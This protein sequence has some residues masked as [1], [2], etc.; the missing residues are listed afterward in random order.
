L[1]AKVAVIDVVPGSA[2]KVARQAASQWGVESFSFDGDMTQWGSV[3]SAVKAI[4]ERFGRID[5]W[6]NNV[7]NPTRAK[8][9][10]E[11]TAEE[12]D[13]DL[14]RNLR[15]TL[16]CARAVLDVML[17]QKRGRIINIASEAG[18][19]ALP[20][21]CVYGASK[22]GVVGFTRNLAK[23]LAETGVSA[24]A[25]APGMTVTPPL[26]DA[27]RQVNAE[28]HSSIMAGLDRTML[29]RA[30]LAEEVA[31]MVAF[32]ATEAGAYVNATTV[33]VSGGMSD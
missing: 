4:A 33:S 11:F 8:R 23:D 17:P 30:A 22:T 28:L 3:S 2:E 19:T 7:G 14:D 6:V 25:V 12:I 1:G 26:I 10:W 9:F 20:F 31:N 24:V 13:A 5:I 32:L 27:L 18:K 29:P 15:S 21:L 16:Y